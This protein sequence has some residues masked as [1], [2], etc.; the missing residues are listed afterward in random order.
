MQR[1][2]QIAVISRLVNKYKFYCS[3]NWQM[4]IDHLIQ[5]YVIIRVPLDKCTAAVEV[6]AK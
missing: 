1:K 6:D 3:V 4:Q 5:D 2:L